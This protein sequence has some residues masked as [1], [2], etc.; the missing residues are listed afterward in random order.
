LPIV[1]RDRALVLRRPVVR[2]LVEEVGRLREHQEAVAETGRDPEQLMV[3]SR[4]AQPDPFAEARTRSAQVDDDVEHFAG[5]D[6][7][8][9][10]LRLLDL[11]VQAAENSARRARMIVLH[12]VDVDAGRVAE[13]ATVV[14]LEEEAARIAEDFR[15]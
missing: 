2:R 5:D 4:Q 6:A 12:E 7:H 1:P 14:A 8:E 3:L 11:V 15:L 13:S 10:S 9:L